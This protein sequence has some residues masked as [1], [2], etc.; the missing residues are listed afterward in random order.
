MPK[1]DAEEKCSNTGVKGLVYRK[2]GNCY[3]KTRTLGKIFCRLKIPKEADEKD[4][5][6]EFHGVVSAFS[7]FTSQRLYGNLKKQA[8]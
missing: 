8:L 4:A 2:A 3:L 5:G 6:I 1:V 7:L